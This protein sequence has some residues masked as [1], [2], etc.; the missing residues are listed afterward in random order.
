MTPRSSLMAARNAFRA[1]ESCLARPK[2]GCLVT[3]STASLEALLLKAA[4]ADFMPSGLELH[5]LAGSVP[6]ALAYAD[7]VR[8]CSLCGCG[9][10][11]TGLRGAMSSNAFSSRLRG[12]EWSCAKVCARQVEEGPRHCRGAGCA[13]QLAG[14]VCARRIVD[15][16]F[17][18]SQACS[19]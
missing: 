13:P 6:L 15:G 5:V 2:P 16:P 8:S 4:R 9:C 17:L 11:R 14:I 19:H 1:F 18:S 3:C 10:V 7:S 12:A